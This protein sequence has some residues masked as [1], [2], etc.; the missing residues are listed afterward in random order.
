MKRMS[1]RTGKY[2]KRLFD[3]AVQIMSGN[4]NAT[5]SNEDK[6]LN[7][8]RRFNF[9]ASIEDLSSI[10]NSFAFQRLCCCRTVIRV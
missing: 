6:G 2:S 7:K 1:E 10:A 5:K 9:S 3:D 8:G 4:T